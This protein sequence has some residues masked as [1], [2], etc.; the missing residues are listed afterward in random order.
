MALAYFDQHQFATQQLIDTWLDRM[1]AR[2]GWLDIARKRPVP[3]ES[4][5]GNSGYFFYYGTHYAAMAI[6]LLEDP[7][8][9]QHHAGHLT[10]ILVDLQEKNGS[11][12][13][14]PLYQYHE[15]YGT[16]YALTALAR[17]NTFSDK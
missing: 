14:Y 9:Q 15:A 2:I 4:W 1:W 8:R 16:G 3:H 17:I 7:E 11:W 6:D 5:A 13:D 12:W 10:R